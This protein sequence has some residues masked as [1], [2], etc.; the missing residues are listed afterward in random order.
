MI[1]SNGAISVDGQTCLMEIL[2]LDCVLVQRMYRRALKEIQK[3][4][5]GDFFTV[6]HCVKGESK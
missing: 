4:V 6:F 2:H 5:G 3:E 1:E